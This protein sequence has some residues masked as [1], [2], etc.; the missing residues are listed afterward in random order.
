MFSLSLSIF[1][2]FSRLDFRGEKARILT[3]CQ[4]DRARINVFWQPWSKLVTEPEIERHSSGYISFFS[5][6]LFWVTVSCLVLAAVKSFSI[7]H[8]EDL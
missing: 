1:C 2:K 8:N 5:G 4:A 3:R 6:A 7:F